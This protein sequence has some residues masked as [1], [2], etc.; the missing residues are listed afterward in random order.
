MPHLKTIVVDDDE[1]KDVVF[2][3][4]SHNFTKGAWGSMSKNSKFMVIQIS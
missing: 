4:G 2:Y 3:I 1:G